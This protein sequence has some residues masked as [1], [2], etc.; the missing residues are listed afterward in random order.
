MILYVWDLHI[1]KNVLHMNSLRPE[2][3][4]ISCREYLLFYTS[5]ELCWMEMF[6]S[7]ID[8]WAN[9]SLVRYLI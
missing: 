1:R 2:F 9:E 3:A 8:V 5:N 6:S 4:K 7:E